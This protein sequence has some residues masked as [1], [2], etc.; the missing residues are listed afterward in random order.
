V[1]KPGGQLRTI[2]MEPLLRFHQRGVGYGHPT[3]PHGSSR[4]ELSIEH[5]RFRPADLDPN[6]VENI[7]AQQ[8]VRATDGTS[9][10]IGLL[11]LHRRALRTGGIHRAGN[12]SRGLAPLRPSWAGVPLPESGPA[13]GDDPA[14]TLAVPRAP[15]AP[16]ALRSSPPTEGGERP[17]DSRRRRVFAKHVRPSRPSRAACP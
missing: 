5:D 16:A 1:T 2:T 3:F 11:E 13:P 15:V 10:G 9:T 8:L 14:V 7:H 17:G 12:R 6:A 4:G